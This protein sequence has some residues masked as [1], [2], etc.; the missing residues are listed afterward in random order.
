MTVQPTMY[1]I[2]GHRVLTPDEAEE[3]ELIM[4]MEE[5]RFREDYWKR[6]HEIMEDHR[7]QREA[8]AA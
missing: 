6:Q 1:G 8:G 7:R 5:E 3:R 2:R 4:Q